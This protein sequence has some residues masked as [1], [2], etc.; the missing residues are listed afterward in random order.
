[1]SK[2]NLTIGLWNANG[3]INH[4]RELEAFLL[5]NKIDIM[6]ISETHCTE[7]S[8]CKI[9]NYNTILANH[10]SGNSYGGAAIIIRK[11]LKYTECD[12][13]TSN[14]VQAAIIQIDAYNESLMIGSVYC[15]PRF[16]LKKQEFANILSNF[17]SKF[18]VGGD[19]NS[20]HTTWGS[21][22]CNPKGNELFNCINNMNVKVI[23]G[24]EPTYW[25]TDPNKIPDLLDIFLYKG[26]NPNRMQVKNSFDLNS[27]HS[28]VILSCSAALSNNIPQSINYK[29]YKKYLEDSLSLNVSLKSHYEIDVAVNNFTQ[30]IKLAKEAS[31]YDFN[32]VC[33]F[34]HFPQDIQSKIIEKRKIRKQ[35]QQNRYPQLKKMLNRLTK[36][37]KVLLKN[38]NEQKIN[39]KLENLTPDKS[40]DYSLWKAV[41]SKY[42]SSHRKSPI[43]T[44][45]GNWIKSSQDKADAFRIRLNNIFKPFTL[46]SCTLD[47]QNINNFVDAP[48]PMSPYITPVTLNEVINKIKSLAMKKAHGPDEI[49]PKMMSNLPKKGFLLLTYIYNSILRLGYFPNEWKIAK[50]IMIPKPG[51]PTEELSSYRPISLLSVVSKVFERLLLV[52]L[53]PLLADMI[54]DHQFGFRVGHSTQE[55]CHRVVNYIREG[56]EHKQ[57]ISAVFLDIQEAFD[58][59]WIE[60]LLFKIKQIVSCPMF[61]LLKSYLTNRKFYVQS[62]SVRSDFGQITAGVPQGSVLGPHLFNIYTRDMP[63][64]TDGLNATFADDSAVMCRDLDPKLAS[65]RLEA[66]LDEV[67]IWANRWNI[68]INNDKCG[69]LTFTL[70]RQ[71][72]PPVK[73]N[74]KTIPPVPTIKYLGLHLDRRLTFKEHIS[75]KRKE[76]TFRRRKLYYMLS[77]SSKLSIRNKLNIYKVIIK[78]IWTYCLPIWGSASN[79]NIEIIQRCQNIT[80][81]V[82]TGA[83]N[84]ITNKRLHK[85]LQISSIKDEIALCN[86]K[87]KFRLRSHKNPLANCLSNYRTVSRLKRKRLIFL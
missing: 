36:D 83:P 85:E 71:D 23:S 82:C 38:Y 86:R 20:K 44:T 39:T 10:P 43:R 70:N 65:E 74:N 75:K 40:S 3:L 22:L 79:S 41:S 32:T 5:T 6:L 2:I 17:G 33:D 50:V 1:M 27:D 49:T 34:D 21:R 54:P 31:A 69:H 68:Q 45:N 35:W 60:G 51:K 30:A 53:K 19:F 87:Y 55:Q 12:N 37:L 42:K 57:Y 59:V 18:I 80:L 25:P 78:P 84:Y 9:S 62:D 64:L 63:V 58:R 15:R 13:V 28:P 73:I 29:Q 48:M 46:N 76:I 8:Y 67:G 66:Y 7:R 4:I 56:F 61:V 52:R 24:N 14:A 81:R 26:V 16:V 47:L 72:C 77:K 11:S